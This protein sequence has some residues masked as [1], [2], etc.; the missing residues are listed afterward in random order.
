MKNLS[1]VLLAAAIVIGRTASAEVHFREAAFEDAKK[2]AVKEHK[3]IMVDFYTSWCGWCKV[4]DRKTY[5][6]ENVGKIADAK[7]ISIKIDA[8]HGEGVELAKYF[9]VRGYPTIVFLKEDGSL[10]DQVVG[11]QDAEHFARSLQ[12][13]DAGGSKAVIDEIN[14]AHPPADPAKWAIAADYYLQRK[15]NTRA[16]GAYRQMADL[17]PENKGHFREEALYGIAYLTEGDARY[18]ALEKALAEFPMREEGQRAAVALIDHYMTLSKPQDASRI[19]DKWAMNHPDDAQAFNAFAWYAAQHKILLDKAD[20]YI[21]RAIGLAKD[22]SE[23][24]GFMDTQAELAYRSGHKADAVKIEDSAIA[25]LDPQ[26]DH[27]LLEQLTRE[28]GKYD[29]TIVDL[30]DDTAAQTQQTQQPTQAAKQNTTKT[31]AH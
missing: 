19:I 9:K 2:L 7:F 6:D 15:D 29:G 4:L 1:I 3:K 10:I 24:A 20:T 11:Y 23:K 31:K 21:K 13:A 25:L 27:K 14:S 18:D 8:E 17:D 22:N 5:S 12:M 28:K 16:L 30:D 26:K